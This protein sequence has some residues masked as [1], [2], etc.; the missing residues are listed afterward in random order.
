MAAQDIA[1]A[2]QRVESVLRRRPEAGLHADSQAVA[3]WAGELRVVASHANGTQ[4]RTDMPAEFGG[5]GEHVTPGWLM[6]AG[7][8]SCLCTGIAM[9]AAREQIELERLEVLADSQTD[10]R[11][12]L[13]VAGADG[14]AV[15]AGPLSVQLRVRISAPGVDAQRLRALV[16]RSHRCAPM[17]TALERAVPMALA[18][19][20]G[21]A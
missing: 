19:E 2:L 4:A 9:A 15:S 21:E 3:R 1:A 18:I 16:E 12:I 13:G 6:R 20:V 17:S 8:A 7:V 5:G 14:Q 11:G 10:A